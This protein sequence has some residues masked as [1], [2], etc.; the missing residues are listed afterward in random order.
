M[1]KTIAVLGATGVYGRH[2]LPRLMAGGFD[3]RALV[4]TPTAAHHAHALGADVRAADTF[5]EAS[6]VKALTGCDVAI[7]L[8]T[9]LRDDGSGSDYAGNDRV[10][11]EGV[12]IFVSACEKA[13]VGRIV[14]QSIALVHAAGADWADED[15]LTHPTANPVA[16]AA[17]A[18]ARAM[19]DAVMRGSADWL[20]LR[21]GLFYGP[22]TTFDD[23]WFAAARA[24]K[25]RLPGDGSDYVSLV[26]IADM[27]AATVAAVARDVSNTAL[28]I[29]DDAPAQW[30]DVFG[31]IAA[32]I[33]APAPQPG[34]R[35]GFPSWRVRNTRACAALDWAPVYADYRAGLTR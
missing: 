9:A 15:T 33:G 18:S 11:R 17:N 19:E 6:L 30:R 5:D 28:I 32:S 4:R 31:F 29:A 12:P 22:G 21:G 14:Q 24:G 35:L 1:T 23:G 27:A 7:N 16:E 20:I 13:G 2:L 8:A 25:L 3:L 10:R 34:G 26:Q